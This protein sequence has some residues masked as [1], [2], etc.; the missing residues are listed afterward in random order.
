MKL[1]LTIFLILAVVCAACCQWSEPVKVPEP[2]NTIY[3]SSFPFITRDGKRLYFASDRLNNGLEDIFYSDW[4][5][6]KWGEP[7]HLGPNINTPSQRDLSPS[8]TSDNQTLYFVKYTNA[9]SY[10]IFYAAW[11]DTGWGK[12][13]NV[14]PPINTP[15]EEL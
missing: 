1:M 11:E 2:I 4:D 15:G 7:L 13:V 10:D 3:R 8:V 5:G 9:N 6:E 14:G 12:A